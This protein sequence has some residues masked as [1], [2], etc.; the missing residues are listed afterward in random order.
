[1]VCGEGQ[2][3]PGVTPMNSAHATRPHG[4]FTRTADHEVES[5][6][7]TFCGDGQPGRKVDLFICFF[8]VVVVVF[9]LIEVQG[10]LTLFTMKS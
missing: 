9:T 10:A 2:A 3:Y 8:F 6:G 4:N 5:N 1:M 7:E